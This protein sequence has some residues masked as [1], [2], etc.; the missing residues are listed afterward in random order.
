MNSF[1]SLSFLRLHDTATWLWGKAMCFSESLPG[2]APLNSPKRSLPGTLAL[3]GRHLGQFFSSRVWARVE[4]GFRSDRHIVLESWLG[5]GPQWSLQNV[6][7][8]RTGAF[9]FWVHFCFPTAWDAACHVTD[10]SWLFGWIGKGSLM[11]FFMVAMGVCN[12][13]TDQCVPQDITL[14]FWSL[15]PLRAFWKL[16]RSLWCWQDVEQEYSSHKGTFTHRGLGFKLVMVSTPVPVNT[17]G[18]HLYR[19]ACTGFAA[20]NCVSPGLTT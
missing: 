4:L 1:S 2:W 15:R 6:S 14:K 9:D 10:A 13:R 12:I 16:A 8:L 18:F 17:P 5:P 11:L 19:P 20:Q 3:K 7:S